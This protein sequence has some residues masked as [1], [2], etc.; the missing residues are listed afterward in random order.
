MAIKFAS[1]KWKEEKSILIKQ[2]FSLPMKKFAVHMRR[3][4]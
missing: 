2:P 1:Q 3:N 4:L